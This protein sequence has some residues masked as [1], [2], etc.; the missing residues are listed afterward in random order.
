MKTVTANKI[1][2]EEFKF[3]IG[4]VDLSAIQEDL[5][6]IHHSAMYNSIV[7]E[8]WGFHLSFEVETTI[9]FNKMAFG[10][11]ITIQD[12]NITDIELWNEE[13]ELEITDSMLFELQNEVTNQIQKFI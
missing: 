1:K 3:F 13:D 6:S 10:S 4:Y 7:L 9:S 12:V 2:L 11:G 5:Q 8:K